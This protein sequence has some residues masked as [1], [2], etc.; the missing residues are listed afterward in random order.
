MASACVFNNYIDRGIDAKMERTQKRALVSGLVPTKN[1]LV[2][3][4]L[5]LILGFGILIS[6]TNWLTVYLG[7]LAFIT[8]VVF[9]G[10]S[11]RHSVHGTL[12]GSVAGALPPVAGYTAVTNQL[13]LAAVIIFLILVCW[14]MA[15][16]YSIAIYRLKDYKAA[17]LPVM[18]VVKGVKTTKLQIVLYVFAFMIITASLTVFGYTGYSYLL[19]MVSL[20]TAWF[21]KGLVGFNAEDNTKWAKGMFGFSLIVI[22]GLAIML[23]ANSFLP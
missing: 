6:A 17:G 19:V 1:A 16:F 7:V 22:L 20:G 9:Y 15:H 5:L 2:Y 23:S 14:Q 11:K 8:Y 13:D 3:A 18:P 12:V 21:Y 4:C 10:Y